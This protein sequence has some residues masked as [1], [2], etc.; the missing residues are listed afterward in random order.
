MPSGKQSK[1]MRRAIA[2]EPAGA[3][4]R[5]SPGVVAVATAAVVLLVVV[6]VVATGRH[7]RSDGGAVAEA[8]ALPGISEVQ[9]MLRGIPQRENVLGR[10]A[11]PVTMV[12]YADLQCPYCRDFE[13]E[14]MPG[15]VSRYVRPGKLKVE[16]RTLAFV[17]PDS[18]K[19]RA[20]AIAAGRQNKLFELAQTLYLNQGTENT[21]WL[22]AETIRS[23]AA[24][25]AGLDVVRLLR[26]SRSTPVD[27][28]ARRLDAQAAADRV[29]GTPT[30]LVGRTGT[31]LHH[32]ALASPADGRSVAAAVQAALDS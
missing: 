28:A 26:E 27:A 29:S 20:A 31:T 17:G 9:R 14:A 16:L 13:T 10:P 12:V 1:R 21:G 18:V 24:G 22:S 15:L 4:R 5:L 6:L 30:I 25:I 2:A 7:G 19:G 8:T 32:V 23:A 11:A 3:A